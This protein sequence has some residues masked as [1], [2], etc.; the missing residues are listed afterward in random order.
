MEEAQKQNGESDLVE[1]VV[2][3]FMDDFFVFKD[4]FESS[5]H[6]LELVL[7]RCEKKGLILN[8]KKCHF[9]V[10]QGMVL[11]HIVFSRGIEVNK[12]KIELISNFP[13]IKYVKDVR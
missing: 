6:P 10:S 9:I 2:K 11:G 7:Q 13:T 12:S 1:K 5:T 8:W 3:V 4:S